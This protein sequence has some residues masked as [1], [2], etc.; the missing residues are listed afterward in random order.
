MVKKLRFSTTAASAWAISTTMLMNL[1]CV[2]KVV[3]TSVASLLYAVRIRRIE[4]WSPPAS[5]GALATCY[6]QWFGGV[7][8]TDRLFSDSSSSVTEP[9]HV[10]SSPP[11][12]TDAFFW[13]N[14]DNLKS[15]LFAVS[16]ASGSIIDLTIEAYVNSGETQLVT[17]V[18]TAAVGV[19]Y[20]LALD[21]PTTHQ[22]VPVLIATTF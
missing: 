14:A 17:T 20:T 2:G 13:T 4:I 6:V 22:V 11:P 18:A 8:G 7:D 9:A 12:G 3:N 19:P 5:Q 21:G 1:L 15:E 10:A 16:A